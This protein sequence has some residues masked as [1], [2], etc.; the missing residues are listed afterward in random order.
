MFA[1]FLALMFVGILTVGLVS[2]GANKLKPSDQ[3]VTDAV[4]VEALGAFFDA[5]PSYKTKVIKIVTDGTDLLNGKTVVTRAGVIGWIKDQ[6]ASSVGDVGSDKH[7]KRV[8]G[9]LL[10]AYL[11]TWDQTTLNF[12]NAD[13][14]ALLLHL[15]EIVLIAAQ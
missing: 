15:S 14:K 1:K 5:N 4:L 7:L 10:D 3:A 12:I 13:D 2:C 11:P 6:V 9:I 8:M